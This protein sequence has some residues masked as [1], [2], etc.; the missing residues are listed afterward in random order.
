MLMVSAK[1]PGGL[2]SLSQ[3]NSLAGFLIEIHEMS[4]FDTELYRVAGPVADHPGY[5]CGQF[6]AVPDQGYEGRRAHRLDDF[7]DCRCAAIG[8]EYMLGPHAKLKSTHRCQSLLC[9]G[10]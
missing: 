6:A 4:R 10:R 8:Q 7:D 9:T 2:S 5:A 1:P 3:I